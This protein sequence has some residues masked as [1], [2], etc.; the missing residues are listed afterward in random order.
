MN[1]Q[2][3]P[4]ATAVCHVIKGETVHGDHHRYGSSARPFTT[5]EI[6]LD[7]LVW[8]RREPGPLFDTP[9]AEI[10][11]VLVETGSWIAR[12]PQGLIAQALEQ[13]VATSPLP[14]EVLERSY[15]NLGSVFD[16]NSMRFQI[17]N[18][19]GGA[20]VLDGWREV[21]AP[22]GRRHRVRAFPPRLVHIVAGNAPGVS[23]LSIVRG[24]LVKGVNLL[25]VPSNDL[26]TATAILRAIAAVAP[27]HP[28]TRSFSAVYWRGGDS[29]IEGQIFRPQYFDKL[30]AWGGESALKSAKQYVGPGFELVA[31]DPKTSISLLG[32][33]IF[34]SDDALKEAAERASIDVT[35][36]NQQACASSRFQFVEGTVEQI[37]RYCA[38]LQARLGIER[39]MCSTLQ[40]LPSNLRE[41]IE[42]LRGM[43]PYYRVWGDNR[44]AGIVIRSEEPVEFHPD[45]RVV[46]VI[47][48]A[49]LEQ[50]G[51]FHANVATQTV[52]VWPSA[53]KQALRNIL[54]T[55][56]VQRVVDLGM[57][58]RVETGLP[59]D[60]FLPL[61]R[62]V[63]WV[64]DEG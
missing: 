49:S 16:R 24:A 4:T 54:A 14:R 36:M 60:G 64:N 12:D 38:A 37:D 63:R 7:S 57:A 3:K 21:L 59:H 1:A 32:R 47:P 29:E 62:F 34:A 40:P 55:A 51:E 11:D 13:S 2:V 25:K 50:A 48:V 46:N 43:E 15:R 10:I 28:V 35:L 23:A 9:V 45:G 52:G 27:G 42:G 26:F 39:D 6:K 17:D 61:Q 22:S 18:E 44:G 53:R 8:S 33:E 31:F 20:D 5:P 56:G 58:G 30:V 19:L 41:E